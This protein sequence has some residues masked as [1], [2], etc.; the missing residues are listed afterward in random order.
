MQE[1]SV[2]PLRCNYLRK[3]H[4]YVCMYSYCLIYVIHCLFV[5]LFKYRGVHD[6]TKAWLEIF[7]TLRWCDTQLLETV[8]QRNLFFS[9]ASEVCGTTL[10]Y[11][12]WQK[13][14]PQLPINHTVMRG[15]QPT[16]LQPFWIQT[17][18]SASSLS[19]GSINYNETFNIFFIKF[20]CWTMF[21]RYYC[22]CF[23]LV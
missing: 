4:V 3:P 23:E 12:V 13:Q 22:Q 5:I 8:L 11:D 10:S 14:W 15:K 18:G 20:T 1:P 19:V 6:L 16:D 2:V 9:W 21:C 7:L 17:A